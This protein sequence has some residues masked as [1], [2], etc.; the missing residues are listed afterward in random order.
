M[1]GLL[2]RGTRSNFTNLQMCAGGGGWGVEA[3]VGCVG[4][5]VHNGGEP[6]VGDNSGDAGRE[7]WVGCKDRAWGWGIVGP[8]VNLAWG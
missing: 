8:Q 3:L 5:C 7:A 4:L 6:W 1:G 2:A